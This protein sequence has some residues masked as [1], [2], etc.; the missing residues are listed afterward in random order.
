MKSK[1]N[2][3]YLKMLDESM[4][5]IEEGGF[6]MKKVEGLDETD[7][8]AAMTKERLSHETVFRNVRGT[9]HEK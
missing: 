7:R 3:E 4:K 5:E 6:V 1:R 2:E 9:V 8:Q